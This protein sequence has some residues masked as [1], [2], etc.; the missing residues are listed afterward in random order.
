MS[1]RGAHNPTRGRANWPRVIF[2]DE[3]KQEDIKELGTSAP[4]AIQVLTIIGQIE[5]H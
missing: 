2:M 1:E 3:V 4:S 5:G